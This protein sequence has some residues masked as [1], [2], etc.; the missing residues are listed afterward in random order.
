[1]CYIILSYKESEH[2]HTRTIILNVSHYQTITRQN[3]NEF[4]SVWLMICHLIYLT[5]H[6]YSIFR[7]HLINT[8]YNTF[9]AVLPTYIYLLIFYS[10]CHY[11]CQLFSIYCFP[12]WGIKPLSWIMGSITASSFHSIQ[13]SSAML[14]IN[15]FFLAYMQLL[16]Q[17][18]PFRSL[19]F[20]LI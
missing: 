15:V 13:P 1:M 10:I 19:D 18:K 8:C 4:L 16:F 20:S 17:V 12:V 5:Q 14:S 7:I 2:R 6:M 9:K 11:V 3:F